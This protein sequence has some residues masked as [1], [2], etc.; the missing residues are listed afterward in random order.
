LHGHDVVNPAALDAVYDKESPRF[1]AT[2]ACSE[3]ESSAKPRQVVAAA[4]ENVWERRGVTGLATNGETSEIAGRNL[5]KNSQFF[6]IECH[7]FYHR[8]HGGTRRVAK[9]KITVS[10]FLGLLFV[11]PITAAGRQESGAD[12]EVNS[13]PDLPR[14]LEI[15]A[16][17]K[18]ALQGFL[19][20]LPSCDEDGNIYVRPYVSQWKAAR[21]S[22]ESPVQRIKPEGNLG[23]VFKN[24]TLD[25]EK[26]AATEI[27]VN[28]E[29]G[30]YQ[31]GWTQ[32]KNP[33]IYVTSFAK[34]GSV[35]ART[36]LEIQLFRP[37]HLAVFKSGE[38]LLSGTKGK[39]QNTPYTAVFSLDGKLL[40]EVVEPE[41]KEAVTFGNAVSGADG[42]VYLDRAASPALIYAV[43]PSGEVVRKLRIDAGRSGYGVGSIRAFKGGLVIAFGPPLGRIAST[44]IRIVTYSGDPVAAYEVTENSLTPQSLACYAEG[45]FTFVSTSSDNNVYVYTAVP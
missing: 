9:V 19:M 14:P 7:L 41:D 15:K 44:I 26:L 29:G 39:A 18:T 2:V 28:A 35:E 17:L 43:S 23:E 31:V 16:R 40:K 10:L 22:F 4:S 34:D 11:S 21:F 25:G 1:N 30:V 37:D 24:S 12:K 6:G 36:R 3:P 5:G 38:F 33:D 27:V 32:D 45:S 42:N 20:G 13:V 8:G